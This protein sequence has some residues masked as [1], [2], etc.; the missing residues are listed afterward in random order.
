MPI[1]LVT[2]LERLTPQRLRGGDA[3]AQLSRTRRRAGVGSNPSPLSLCR[4]AL[5]T[6]S[7][8]AKRLLALGVENTRKR[9]HKTPRRKVP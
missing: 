7:I 9:L 5:G 2:A 4:T 6:G 1:R 8:N 3:G